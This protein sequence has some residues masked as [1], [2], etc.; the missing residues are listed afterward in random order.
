MAKGEV[1][2]I[3]KAKNEASKSLDAITA[4]LKNLTDQQIIAGDSADKADGK[5]ASL[6]LELTKL[7]TNAQNLQQL[8]NIGAVIDKATA[9][10][11]RQKETLQQAN[12]EQQKLA[13]QSETMKSRQ[14]EL[15]A[16]LKL[17]TADLE[18]QKAAVTS[19]RSSLSELNKEATTLTNGQRNAQ[20]SLDALT[21][22]IAT[23][24]AA[25]EKAAAKHAQLAAAV[26]AAEK[27]TKRLTT[28]LEAAERALAKRQA[29]LDASRQ[30]EAGLRDTLTQNA[31]AQEKNAA[32]IAEATSK[33]Q[34]EQKAA[35]AAKAAVSAL[36]TESSSLSKSQQS[37]SRDMEKSAATTAELQKGLDASQAEFSQIQ[38]VADKARAKVGQASASMTDV[39]QS[40][41]QAAAQLA[42][43]AARMKVLQAGSGTSSLKTTLFDPAAVTD[44]LSALS[45]AQAVV[46]ATERDYSRAAVS[47]DDLKN[48][49]IAAGK[50]GQTLSTVTTAVTQQ[51][52]AVDGAEASWKAAEAEVKRLAIA[53][54]EAG[55]PSEQ[56]AAAL[57][58]AQGQAK[59]AKNEFLNQKNVG[60]QLAKALQQA[61]VGAGTLS[62][63]E[64]SLAGSTRAA[65]STMNQ[66]TQASNALASAQNN[67]QQSGSRLQ[68]FFAS[69]VSGGNRVATAAGQAAGGLAKIRSGAVSA[70]GPV[71]SLTG[72]LR[73]LVAQVAG[74]Y[75][76]KEGITGIIQTSNQFDALSAKLG[77]A[78]AGDVTKANQALDY[79]LAVARNLKLPLLET[80]NSY[81]QLASAARGTSLEGDGVNKIFTAFAQAAR[82]TR[83]STADLDGI[84]RAL[85]QSISKGKV[86][87][88]ELRGQL[89]DRLPGA[90]QLMASALGVG[91]KDLEKML[92]KG[93]LTTDTLVR[94]AAEVSS[95]V[96]PELEKALNSPQAKLQAFQ[97]S[98]TELQLKLAQ[99][100]FLDAIANAAE[101]F[102]DALSRPDVIQSVTELGQGLA[103]LV[104]YFAQLEDPVGKVTTLFEVL[105]GL[106]L[107]SWIGGIITGLV[108]MVSGLYALATAAAAADIALAPILITVGALAALF[109]LPWLA[110]WAYDN[111]PVFAE[112]V[113]KSKGAALQAWSGIVEGWNVAGA[114]LV[115]SFEQ[116][117]NNIMAMWRSMM[118]WIATT[119]SDLLSKVGLGG[120][121]EGWAAEAQKAS[122]EAGKKAADSQKAHEQEITS[123]HAKAAKDRADIDADIARQVQDKLTEISR[124]GEKD[125]AKGA[126]VPTVPG[127]NAGAGLGTVTPPSGTFKPDT[128]D[129]DAKAAERAAKKRAQLEQS[130]ADQISSIR[131]RLDQNRANDLDTQL[132]GVEE[133][134]KG[135]YD[136]LRKLGL[137]ETSEQW[138]Q[139]D[140]LKAQEMQLVRNK[141][142]KAEQQAQD[143]KT[144]E[145]MQNINDLMSLRREL[146][147]QIK[148]AEDHGDPQTA[149]KLKEQFNNVNGLISAAAD[150]MIKFWEAAGGPKAD[151]AIAKLKALK[152]GLKNIDDGAILTADNINK[153]L[154]S[155]ATSAGDSF[156]DKIA[157]TGD[158]FGSLKESFLDFVSSFLTGIAKMIMQQIIFNALSSAGSAGGGGG[159]GGIIMS[160]ISAM[161]GSAHTGGIAGSPTLNKRSVNPGVFA[162]AVRYHTGGVVGLQP[163]EVPII[164]KKNEEV[165]TEDDP[166]HINN[167]GSSTESGNGNSG[168]SNLQIINAIDSESVV[169]AGLSSPAG[170][171]TVINL[172]KANKQTFKSIL[173]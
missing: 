135:L 80:A 22:L 132:K 68:S 63:A 98:W 131:A 47:A 139:V 103:N 116:V 171:K 72:E 6:S 87:A 105:V 34:S 115:N 40:A 134:Y 126:V 48:A 123:I 121:V 55:Q 79:S 12:S 26:D 114:L 71:G 94:M 169:Q 153:T 36:N 81:S 56:L 57:G 106:Q 102:G 110:T 144:R 163:W 37:L 129:A 64:A 170:V 93:Q 45:K 19:A 20:R 99:S 122:E 84:F 100:G 67:A 7:R 147:E 166:R 127:V 156:I 138:K 173:A 85:T 90:I 74:L 137:S 33:L 2:L 77:V 38:A 10:L 112:L 5:L 15:S 146:L 42:T 4:S 161:T 162:N 23:Q 154:L 91:T 82:V 69:L 9:A 29:A 104:N 95:R 78:F 148:Y 83:T 46:Q 157:E 51:K 109:A 159:L 11:E 145:D 149:N 172:V 31:T 59:L 141:A 155:T 66:A 89:G 133:K 111:F 52:A 16:S 152:D 70:S 117:I 58:Q 3:I 65:T 27:P 60:D 13:S 120:L 44:A 124:R 50:A 168:M 128:S 113:L 130:V 53:M 39:G 18:K 160:G 24:E 17:A 61:G 49:T 140:A 8:A 73:G 25:L 165:L 88:E 125:R 28:S 21:K 158:V 30:K 86:Q 167:V 76:I 96:A 164:A 41:V 92:E 151:L 101:R 43:F 97:N 150:N 54:R 32:A 143:K 142:A 136:D 1:D 75:A 118:S 62:S 119:S 14:Q 35:D 107:A 108:S